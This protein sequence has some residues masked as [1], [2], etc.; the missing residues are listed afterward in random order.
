ME[1]P[2][3][4]GQLLTLSQKKKK[5]ATLQMPCTILI[6]HRRNFNAEWERPFLNK[7]QF[8]KTEKVNF[9][10]KETHYI[11]TFLPFHC[12]W[13]E[14]VSHAGNGPQACSVETTGL[15]DIP[16]WFPAWFGLSE[17][18]LMTPNPAA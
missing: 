5:D 7:G 16:K 4:F 6:I 13:V 2:T 12:E 1:A 17:S 8:C 10:K 14:I 18:A 15:C 11:F 9:K 3:G